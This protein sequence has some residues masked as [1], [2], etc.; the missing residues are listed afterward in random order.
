M[1]WRS[2]TAVL[3][4]CSALLAFCTSF[5]GATSCLPSASAVRQEYHGA[6]PSWTLRAVGHEGVKCWYPGTQPTADNH[7][8]ETPPLADDLASAA[9]STAPIPSAVEPTTD[10]LGSSLPSRVAQ[11][12]LDPVPEE[13][14]FAE[15]FAAVFEQGFFGGSSLMRQMAEL[16][17]GPV[18]RDRAK[19]DTGY[20]ELSL[21]APRRALPD[22][23][24]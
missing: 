6:W 18:T 4:P 15:R 10:G 20:D 1:V 14:S 5:A 13:G 23:P 3:L 11:I 8:H 21:T 16:V 12:G 24:R 2:A 7:R 22:H 17:I 9:E 19:P